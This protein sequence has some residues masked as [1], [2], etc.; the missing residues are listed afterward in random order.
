MHE[1][2][3]IDGHP[4]LELVNDQGDTIQLLTVCA[5]CGQVRSILFLT[6]DR[7]YCTSCR[8]E[9]KAPPRMFPVS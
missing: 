8:T 4:T 7:W 1:P 9:G 5:E 2:A 3:V 6:R